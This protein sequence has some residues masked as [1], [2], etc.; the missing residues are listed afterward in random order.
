MSKIDRRGLMARAS[1]TAAAWPFLWLPHNRAL[2]NT[3]KFRDYPFT[4]GVASGD[5]SADGFVIWT[6]L[7]PEPLSGGGMPTEDVQVKWRV[8]EDEGMKRVVREGTATAAY[9]WGHSVHVELSGLRP[10][11][12]Y[13]YQFDV[14][15]ESSQAGGRE[16]NIE[17]KQ[18]ECSLT[19]SSVL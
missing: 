17:D 16:R 7:A 19:A 13:W 14:G 8:A 11:R 4:L 1:A 5:P 3:T 18:T 9:D 15:S 6:R 10:D 12:T 2:A